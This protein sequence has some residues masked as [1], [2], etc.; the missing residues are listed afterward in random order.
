MKH[1]ILSDKMAHQVNVM[2]DNVI[3]NYESEKIEIADSLCG[4]VDMMGFGVDDNDVTPFT[5][6]ILKAMRVIS[7]YND[8]IN[9]LN[10][11]RDVKL[12][13]IGLVQRMEVSDEIT[14]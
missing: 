7:N 6:D 1:V 2:R 12:P 10:E 5:N 14:E 3:R 11:T 9:G 13:E 4:L 8:V